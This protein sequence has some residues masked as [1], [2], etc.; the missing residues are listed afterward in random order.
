MVDMYLITAW[1]VLDIPTIGQFLPMYMAVSIG[2]ALVV[3][4]L[5]VAHPHLLKAPG[6]KGFVLTTI[7]A[8][9]LVF[10]ALVG[11]TVLAQYG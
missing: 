2:I 8:F 11:F 9:L 7:V 1:L 10:A 3:A 5:G 4:L 6:R